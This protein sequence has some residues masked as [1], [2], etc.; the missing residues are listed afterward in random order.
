MKTLLHEQNSFYRH[1]DICTPSLT[2]CTLT[3]SLG[4]LLLLFIVS[5]TARAQMISGQVTDV[6]TGQPLPFASVAVDGTTQG[7]SANSEGVFSLVVSGKSSVGIALRVS[8]VGYETRQLAAEKSMTIA[9]KP[10]NKT[11]REVI[12]MPDSSL[13]VLL[14]RAYA[15]IEQNYPVKPFSMTCFYRESLKTTDD[16]Y[17]YSG[18][19]LTRAYSTGYQNPN[20]DGQVQ[21]LK[22]RV[23]RFAGADTMTNVHY[24]GGPF[25][26][27]GWNFVKRRADFLK[28]D[29]SRYTYTLVEETRYDDRPTYIITFV[30]KTKDAAAQRT[31]VLVIDKQTLGYRQIE[32]TASADSAENGYEA[33]QGNKVRTTYQLHNGRW[34]LQQ[35]SGNKRGPKGRKPVIVSADLL[36]TVIDTADVQPIPYN[37]R[38]GYGDIFSF[39]ESN[40]S[41]SFWN[42][43]TTIVPETSL[44]NSM[45]EAQRTRLSVAPHFGESVLSTL[46]KQSVEVKILKILA[47]Q[48]RLIGLRYDPGLAS[49]L[50][51][52]YRLDYP[53][54]GVR[55][56]EISPIE[57]IPVYLTLGIGYASPRWSALYKRNVCVGARKAIS[58]GYQLTV[59]YHILLRK[60]GNPLF[61]KP[62]L[63]IF[64]QNDYRKLADLDNTNREAII[65]GKNFRSDQ[66]NLFLGSRQFGVLL[67]L[68]A[69]QKIASAK[70]LYVNI[71]YRIPISDI[72]WV[73][74]QEDRL[75]FRRNKSEPLTESSAFRLTQVQRSV[76]PKFNVHTEIGI[77]WAF[78]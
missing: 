54:T 73:R 38:F 8:S 65:D 64:G 4:L 43:Y 26:F 74:G 67:E 37:Q 52:S 28:G 24:I 48:E 50:P 17:I 39:Q 29:F 44:F 42:E 61:L 2:L 25:L 36:V 23:S 1:D 78:L 35:V 69:E 12:V 51:D 40:Y 3:T 27:T 49:R 66:I 34:Y 63:G 58:T 30:R 75:L 21:L 10:L 77:R 16:R 22:T 72:W 20:E 71:G 57:P 76:A 59:S 70:W 41:D 14:K 6:A 53:P 18:E 9:L 60:R 11:L 46:Q 68:R 15:R 32:Q 55:F 31:G 19:A 5:V 13:R 45:S 7:T 47:R 33:G 62:T 56:E